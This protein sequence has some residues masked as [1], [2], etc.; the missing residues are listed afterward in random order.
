MITTGRDLMNARDRLGWSQAELGDALRLAG[1][2]R[3]RGTRIRD[4]EN[5]SRPVTGPIAV[6][7]ESFLAGFRP[8]GFGDGD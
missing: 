5:G 1:D 3:H 8:D 2:R 6:A 7:V 4:M